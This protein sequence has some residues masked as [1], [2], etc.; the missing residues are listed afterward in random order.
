M[1]LCIGAGGKVVGDPAITRSSGSSRLD[2]A[3]IRYARAT[4][5]HFHP[6]TRNG[7]A[8]TECVSLPIKF[9]LT[10]SF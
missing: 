2:S 3:A 7:V 5:G 8:F 1:K 4:S 6:A 9:Q 10:D